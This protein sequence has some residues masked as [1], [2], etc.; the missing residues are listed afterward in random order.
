M[1]TANLQ[2]T[3]C[4]VVFSFLKREASITYKDF[5][6]HLFNKQAKLGKVPLLNKLEDKTFMSRQVVR[7]APGEM[8]LS[9]FDDFAQTSTFAWNKLR[10]NC[11]SA[12]K[13]TDELKGGCAGEGANNR[14]RHRAH[15]K[16]T[17]R[18]NETPTTQDKT[19]AAYDKL[20]EEAVPQMKD[21]LDAFG[22]KSSSFINVAIAVSNLPQLPLSSKGYLI[23]L[24]FIAS[25]CTG[26]VSFAI[27][28]TIEH[29]N[30][31]GA[32]MRTAKLGDTAE[33]IPVQAMDENYGITLF[34]IKNGTMV[35]PGYE[36]YEGAEGTEIGFLPMGA[37]TI[38]DVEKTVSR[39][40]LKIWKSEDGKWLAQGMNSKNGTV[41]IEA[42]TN[43]EVVVERPRANL[44]EKVH[45]QSAPIVEI[46]PGDHLILG[47][48]TEFAVCRTLR[49]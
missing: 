34:R 31:K 1:A 14:S 49:G 22:L 35:T 40:H 8:S 29:M 26:D 37:H 12:G 11:D 10:E 32:V 46:E 33:M 41:K 16:T 21:A 20:I 7:L 19:V 6:M 2:E 47:Q 43:E 13:Y 36:L 38:A 18:Q 24:L 45:A 5:A 9:M 27:D 30:G 3:P 39:R 17:T 25:G 28:K 4:F 15:S 42:G 23:M 44:R 48:T